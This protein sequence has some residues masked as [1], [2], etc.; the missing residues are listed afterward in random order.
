MDSTP[1]RSLVFEAN[2]FGGMLPVDMIA[3]RNETQDVIV[4]VSSMVNTRIP[5]S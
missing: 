5:Q 3:V 4:P 1:I 2:A